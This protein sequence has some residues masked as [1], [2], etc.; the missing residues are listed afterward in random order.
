MPPTPRQSALLT[1]SKTPSSELCSLYDPQTTLNPSAR[2]RLTC[3]YLLR[4]GLTWGMEWEGAPLLCLALL[5]AQAQACTG[6]SRGGVSSGS[7]ESQPASLHLLPHQG[8]T[9]PE[10]PGPR[11]LRP[12]FGHTEGSGE[13]SFPGLGA[14]DPTLLLPQAHR[15]TL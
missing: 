12:H 6:P 1:P 14:I 8:Q 9:D 2:P 7:R 3:F 10:T 5:P 13:N 15:A 11:P 4:L